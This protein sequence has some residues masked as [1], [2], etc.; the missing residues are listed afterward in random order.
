MNDR[1][2]PIAA[3]LRDN[4]QLAQVAAVTLVVVAMSVWLWASTRTTL[5]KANAE[6]ATAAGVRETAERFSQQFVVASSAETEEWSRTM[7]QVGEFGIPMSSRLSLAGSVSRIAEAA[8]LS[9]VI[10]RF[11]SGDS[12]V[13]AGSRQMGDITLQPAP[14]SL[15]LQGNGSALAVARTALRL[16]PAVE[17]RGLSLTG[18]SEQ[19]AATFTL[20]V[21]LSEGGSGN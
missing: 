13:T 15:A 8:G 9:S 21:Y 1:F 14:F 10:V 6:I 3:Y 20:V 7:A 19:L 5:T 17:I 16:P 11:V 18:A 12:A 2:A 4:K